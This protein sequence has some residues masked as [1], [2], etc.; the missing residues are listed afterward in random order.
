[1]S[2]SYKDDLERCIEYLCKERDDLEKAGPW[3]MEIADR[4]EEIIKYCRA[5]RG[6]LDVIDYY[7][8]CEAILKAQ[9]GEAFVEKLGKDWYKAKASVIKERYMEWFRKDDESRPDPEEEVRGDAQK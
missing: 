4:Y 3:N 7:E 1:M 2:M 8:G 5:I 9:Q 6:A